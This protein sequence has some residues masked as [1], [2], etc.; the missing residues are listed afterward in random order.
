MKNINYT[1]LALLGLGLI[2]II[3]IIA[4]L[5]SFS[6]QE[7]ELR[8]TFDQKFEERTAFYDKMSKIFNQKS[9]I[10]VKN[11]SSFRKNIDIIMTGRKDAPQLMMKWITEVNPN[12]NY[13][14]VSALYKDLSRAIEAQR[15]GFFNQEKMLQDIVRQ[16]K[17]H[18]QKFP[19]SIY[20]IFFD[21]KPLVYKVIQSS[22]TEEV[23]KTGTDNNTKLDL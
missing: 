14:E 16:H 3:S 11:D 13:A 2:F 12:A 5:V 21:R 17:N 23:I 15:E 8:N 18:I 6:N 7:I 20:N 1:R 9:Q 22:V 10:A 4:T 19:N